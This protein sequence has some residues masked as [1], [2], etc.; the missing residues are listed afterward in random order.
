M[1]NRIITAREEEEL[2]KYVKQRLCRTRSGA[3][4]QPRAGP[5]PG[6]GAGDPEGG[7][8]PIPESVQPS[9][10][11]PPSA[12]KGA[13][14]HPPRSPKDKVT[15]DLDATWQETEVVSVVP[16]E[17]PAR[18][19]SLKVEPRS[20]GPRP[21]PGSPAAEQPARPTLAVMEPSEE[22]SELDDVPEK[23]VT[24]KLKGKCAAGPKV[25]LG[26]SIVNLVGPRSPGW[27]TQSLLPG[28]DGKRGPGSRKKIY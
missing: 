25:G 28:S 3:S 21:D 17:G 6:P 1:V 7:V 18:R 10:E 2:S 14:G 16:A 23:P 8:L 4:F 26:N 27:E 9:P 13:S 11:L 24:E 22:E 15:F 20:P 5:G 12:M 19:G